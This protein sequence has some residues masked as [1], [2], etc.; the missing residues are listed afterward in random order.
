MYELQAALRLYK[1]CLEDGRPEP[2]RTLLNSAFESF[3]FTPDALDIPD[4]K[5]AQIL[6]K[7]L[8]SGN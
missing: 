3:S 4:L 1:L 2:S 7:R 8:P 6:L 5:E